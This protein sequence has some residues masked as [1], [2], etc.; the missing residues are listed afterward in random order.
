MR[1]IFLSVLGV[2]ACGG[3]DHLSVSG[4]VVVQADGTPTGF[5]F[6]RV[7]RLVDEDFASPGTS[8]IAGRCRVG[9]NADGSEVV[10]L[11]VSRPGAPAEG[12]QLRRVSLQLVTD[13]GGT[14]EADLGGDLYRGV[15]GTA[16]CS[17]DLSYVERHDGLVGVVFDCVVAGPRGEATARG[18]LHYEGCDAGS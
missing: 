12:V 13:G 6:A 9:T 18:E 5:E 16:T 14:F 10:S 17:A 8:L 1:W 7:T 4:E 3:S 2:A 15:V 11:A